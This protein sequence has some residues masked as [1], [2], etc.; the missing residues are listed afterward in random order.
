MKYLFVNPDAPVN[1]D[2]PN[3]GLAYAATHFDVSETYRGSNDQRTKS[4]FYSGKR[5]VSEHAQKL[6][7]H[8]RADKNMPSSPREVFDIKVVDFNTKPLPKN[9]FLE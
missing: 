8:G 7:N 5:H 4:A 9:R 6:P 2:V 1:K 3:I